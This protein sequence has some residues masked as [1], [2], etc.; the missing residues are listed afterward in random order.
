MKRE[1]ILTLIGEIDAELAQLHQLKNDILEADQK[2][3]RRSEDRKIYEGYQALQLHNF[4][5]GCENIFKRISIALNGGVPQGEDWHKR[6]LQLMSLEF[7]DLRPAVISNELCAK[8]D[9]YRRFRHV[10][11]NIYTFNLDSDRLQTLI[12]SFR[13]TDELFVDNLH[14]FIEFLKSLAA[15]IS[16]GSS[17]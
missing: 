9:E 13:E 4:Y 8:L 1:Q 16:S 10:V 2:K 14:H 7:P 6:L 15:H 12:D 17:S 3:Q 11:R 5:S